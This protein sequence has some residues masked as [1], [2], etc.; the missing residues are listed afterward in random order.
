MKTSRKNLCTT[1]FSSAVSTPALLAASAAAIGAVGLFSTP[2]TAWASPCDDFTFD[3]L[4]NIVAASSTDSFSV[5][6]HLVGNPATGQGR[7]ARSAE[8]ADGRP[9]DATVTAAIN[10][11]DL[12]L[13]VR[14]EDERGAPATARFLGGR[15][16]ETGDFVTGNGWSGSPGVRCVTPQQAGP[17]EAPAPQPSPRTATVVGEDVDVYNAK[18]EPDGAGQVV[19]ILRVGRQVSLVGDCVPQDWCEV[20]G[21]QVPGGRGWVWGHLELPG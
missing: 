12:T 21:D 14:F 19:G 8:G 17:P 9:H 2:A 13:E 11:R 5:Q 7:A 1:S 16:S 20:V 15:I 3:G 18:N 6:A 10:G 4:L